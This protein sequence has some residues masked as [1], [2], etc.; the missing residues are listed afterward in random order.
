MYLLHFAKNENFDTFWKNC[1]CGSW[2]L[3][4]TLGLLII[5]CI[6]LEYFGSSILVQNNNNFFFIWSTIFVS[7]NHNV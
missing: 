3:L 4:S 1:A 5:F 2:Y 7:M 6:F